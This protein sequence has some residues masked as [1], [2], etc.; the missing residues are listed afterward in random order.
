[1]KIRK[2]GNCLIVVFICMAAAGA[3]G[4]TQPVR[5]PALAG[6]NSSPD[7]SALRD[8]VGIFTFEAPAKLVELRNAILPADNIKKPDT[9]A[10]G[11]VG[12]G[13]LLN[14]RDG[15]FVLTNQHVIDGIYDVGIRFKKQDGMETGYGELVFLGADA[16][17]DLALFRFEN[18]VPDLK[19]LEFMRHELKEGDDVYSAGFPAVGN[20]PIWQFTRGIVSN[21]SVTILNDDGTVQGPYIQ[22]TAPTDP[23]NSGGPL[24]VYS[25]GAFVLAGINVGTVRSR[26]AA[27]FSIPVKTIKGFLDSVLDGEQDAGKEKALGKTLDNFIKVIK[28]SKNRNSNL[29]PYLSADF[30]I[31]NA[32][33]SFYET[34]PASFAETVRVWDSLIPIRNNIC[35]GFSLATASLINKGFSGGKTA[36]EVK[37]APRF[38]NGGNEAD[39]TLLINDKETAT[40]WV[41]ERGE[42]RLRNYE[43]IAPDPE[44]LAKAREN[45]ES[46]KKVKPGNPDILDD[47]FGLGFEAG[48]AYMLDQ[49]HA[50]YGAIG[51]GPV[52]FKFFFNNKNF[53]QIELAIGQRFIKQ[54]KDVS[55]ALCLNTGVGFRRVEAVNGDD[56]GFRPGLSEHVVFEFTTAWITGLYV[57]AGYQFNWY[58]KDSAD[59]KSVYHFFTAGAGYRFF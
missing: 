45:W 14:Y 58:F 20:N 46:G 49:G 37:G 29:V 3:F 43:G 39:V 26:Q 9:A 57:S 51:S 44:R 13:V 48:Y 25:A 1:M 41:F 56:W 21:I 30:V 50:G 27:N 35:Y 6:E 31:E 19:G 8:Y 38:S 17:K 53:W 16:E 5:Q 40:T 36:A 32:E 54:I 33:L 18:A 47:E 7:V 2:K 55:L 28:E 34:R 23:G 12:S 22:H 59:P 42:W 24:L 10:S 52:A 11:W 15:L 4:Q